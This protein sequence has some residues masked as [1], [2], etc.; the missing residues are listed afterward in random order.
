MISM[1][2]VSGLTTAVAAAAIFSAA[3]VVFSPASAAEKNIHCYGVNVCKGHNACKTA[4]NACKGQG[5]CKGLGFVAVTSKT[6][7]DIGG[8]VGE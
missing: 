3:P 7:A 8:K 5:S 4:S 6:C 2:K 1:K